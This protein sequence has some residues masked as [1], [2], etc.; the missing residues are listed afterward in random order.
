[1]HLLKRSLV[2]VAVLL[3]LALPLAAQEAKEAEGAKQNV[4]FGMP[5]PASKEREA[6]LVER[7]QYCLS[8]NATTRTPNWVCWRLTKEDI[9]KAKRGPFAPDPLLPASIAKVTSHVYDAC[10]FDRGHLCPAQDRSRT[11]GDMDAT[12][13]TS[14]IVPQ[15]PKCNQRGWE[16]MEAY[17]RDLTRDGHVLWIA[18]GP[19]GVGGEGKDGVKKVIGKGRVEVT[20]PKQLWKVVLVLPDEKADP[21]RQSRVIAAVFPNDQSVD[22]EWAKY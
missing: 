3:L 14:N 8:Y 2:A 21:T 6:Y 1:M 22:Y 11:Q 7:P 16:R 15:A 20:V 9:G 13:Y 10:G 18:C 4:R 12:F 19:H 17:C 5:G